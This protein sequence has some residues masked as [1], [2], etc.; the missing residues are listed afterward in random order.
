MIL[1][2]L[3]FSLLIGNILRKYVP[4]LRKTLIPASVLG[5]LI[6][7]I[8]STITYYCAGDYFFNFEV[9]WGNGESGAFSGMEILELITYH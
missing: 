9:F 4:F 1:A 3:L 6:L 7:L 8:I 5:G 2:V